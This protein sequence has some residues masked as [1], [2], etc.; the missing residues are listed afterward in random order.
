MNYLLKYKFAKL[1]KKNTK[2]I[3]MT[4]PAA[5]PKPGANL[6]SSTPASFKAVDIPHNAVAENP[7]DLKLRSKLFF[8]AR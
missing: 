4:T 5:H 2:R 7:I 8:F 1:P 3:A 6:K